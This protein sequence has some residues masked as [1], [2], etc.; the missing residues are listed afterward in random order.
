M[1]DSLMTSFPFYNRG[2]LEKL[3]HPVNREIQELWYGWRRFCSLNTQRF[4]FHTEIM[5]FYLSYRV[6]LV[7]RA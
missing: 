3:E 5:K 6:F 2:P 1:K 7:L 4:F